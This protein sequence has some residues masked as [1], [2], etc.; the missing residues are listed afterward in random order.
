VILAETDRLTLRK[1]RREDFPS[2]LRSWNDPDMYRFTGKR[3]NVEQFLTDLF[4]EMESKQPGETG[5]NGGW[6]QVTVER[7]EDGAVVGDLGLGFWVPG[8]RQVELGYRIHPDHHRRGY[9]KEAVTAII[10]WLIE[11]HRIHRF[12][13]V[14]AA[15][16]HA[17]TALLRALGFRREGQFRQSFWCNG[18]WLD[19]EYYALLAS[20]WRSAPR[21]RASASG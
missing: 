14:A 7:K 18:Q 6:Y 5:P 20:E 8:E 3:E 10:D 1:P 16:N 13:G 2:Y 11:R 15:P 12:V 17:S 19:D 4:E 21:S 9:A